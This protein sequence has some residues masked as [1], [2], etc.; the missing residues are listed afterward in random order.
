M[1]AGA[2]CTAFRDAYCK[3]EPI[4]CRVEGVTSDYC[5]ERCSTT[6]G[7]SCTADACIPHRFGAETP[8]TDAKYQ[9]SICKP[10]VDDCVADMAN[11]GCTS[12]S[13]PLEKLPT[14]CQKLYAALER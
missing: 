14:T 13:L 9:W 5:A 4:C 1:S 11:A 7:N 8:C 3:R 2:A 6:Q 12:Y 10:L